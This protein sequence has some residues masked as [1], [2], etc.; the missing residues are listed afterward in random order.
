VRDAGLLSR[1]YRIIEAPDKGT[2]G[3]ESPYPPALIGLFRGRSEGG[4]A[5]QGR[6]YGMTC[7][8]KA[9]GVPANVGCG[10]MPCRITTTWAISF[11]AAAPAAA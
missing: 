6:W 3:G 1:Y 10:A 9:I 4:P 7:L 5:V 2:K 11:P 8:E